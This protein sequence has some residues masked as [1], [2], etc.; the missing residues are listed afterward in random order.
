MKLIAILLLLFVAFSYDIDPN[1]NVIEIK[2]KKELETA[3]KEFPY[4][5][6][7]FY[8]PSCP[9]CKSFNP[10]FENIS[11]KLKE[12]G[13]QAAKFNALNDLVTS[14]KHKVNGYPTV[15]YYRYGLRQPI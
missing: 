15:N 5:L 2:N 11:K 8:S 9:H 7:F 13:I 6:I 1:T 10:T 4:I 14:T 3:L 12:V